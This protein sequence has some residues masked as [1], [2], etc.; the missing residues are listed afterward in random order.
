MSERQSFV[1]RLDR[2]FTRIDQHIH[3][4][5]Y[6]GKTAFVSRA[7]DSKADDTIWHRCKV[8]AN[9]PADAMLTIAY[10]AS[11]HLVENMEWIEVIH[12]GTDF[13]LHKAK[14]R[15]LWL[16]IEMISDQQQS[17]TIRDIQVD[18]PMTPLTWMLPEIYQEDTT[19]YDLLNRYLGIFQSM[20]DDL[21]QK[22]LDSSY[23][24]IQQADQQFLP[25]L[26]QWLD[27][28]GFYLWP[29]VKLRSF[30][31]QAYSLYRIKGT[32]AAIAKVIEIFTGE[33]PWI[34]E[35]HEVDG[36][37]FGNRENLNRKLYGDH[38]FTYTVMVRE[39]VLPTT[40]HYLELNRILEHFTPAHTT[41]KL[42][43][44]KP[45]LFLDSYTYLGINSMLMRSSNLILDGKAN[46]AFA[47]MTDEWG[48][49]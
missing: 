4:N 16:R 6:T 2:Y 31:E 44:L 5:R 43:V 12:N 11:N 46:I 47:S 25:W 35:Q 38:C 10:Y 36:E 40:Q 28:K 49:S 20:M 27:I 26:C 32:K 15:Y 29:E 17:L 24:D 45:Y 33:P 41:Y 23:L 21:D 22:L 39:E 30:M 9:I 18:F 14:G 37:N 13:L 8:D 19:S 42:V 3:I 1:L 48:N 7:L 34:V